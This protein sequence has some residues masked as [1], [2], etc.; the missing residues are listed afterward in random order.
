MSQQFFVYFEPLR[1]SIKVVSPVEIENNAALGVIT[2]SREEALPFLS[3]ERSMNSWFVTDIGGSKALTTNPL[4]VPATG[5]GDFIEVPRLTAAP[6]EFMG[7]GATI[8]L[9]SGII[10]FAV[11][12]SVVGMTF[13][14]ITEPYLEFVLTKRNDPTVVVAEFKVPLFELSR[15]GSLH[16]SFKN[17]LGDYSL[18]TA[19]VVNDYYFEVR[20]STWRRNPQMLGRR[21]NRMSVFK[22]VT[23]TP[24][25]FSGLLATYE[26]N[27]RTMTLEL[28][29][30]CII[31]TPDT[32]NGV[33]VLS[34]KN[35]PTIIESVVSFDLN[36]LMTKGSCTTEVPLDVSD[37]FGVASYPFTPTMLLKKKNG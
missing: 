29:N 12:S 15:V 33:L 13:S 25:D 27:S 7:V 10:E 20:R 18:H 32:S 16:Y 14:R 11:P 5:L 9:S 35:D 36:Q 34:R 30:N 23:R 22:H 8:F 24:K 37:N 4:D 2:I 3:G 31:T 19:K 26:V 6:S 1:G 21:V 28:K 17:D